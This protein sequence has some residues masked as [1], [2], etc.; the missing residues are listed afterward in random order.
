MIYIEKLRSSKC[1]DVA[2]VVLAAFLRSSSL[3]RLGSDRHDQRE[4][5]GCPGQAR[6]RRQITIEFAGGINR[7]MDARP[8]R[9]VSSSRLV[10]IGRL[11][12]H[13]DRRKARDAD[14]PRA[15]PHRTD[16]GSQ[17][18]AGAGAG[19]PG[20]NPKAVELKKLFEEASPPPRQQPRS[21]DREVQRGR[22]DRPQ[23]PRLLLQHRLRHLQKKDEKQAEAA[24]LKAL[25]VKPDYAEAFNG[26]AT[27][28]NNQKRSTKPR[29]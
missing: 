5:R 23:L 28:Y 25:E 14:V 17:L 24:W 7:K 8:I 12:G 16:P 22:A 29:R 26:L 20:E 15:G 2:C 3:G 13:R 11:Q 4:G 1:L 19:G 21:G 10:C 6:R 18:R 27:L 9:R